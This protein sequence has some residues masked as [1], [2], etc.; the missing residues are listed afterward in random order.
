MSFTYTILHILGRDL[1]SGSQQPHTAAMPSLPQETSQSGPESIISYTH[2]LT[3]VNISRDRILTNI[4][5][6]SMIILALII[7]LVRFVQMG[8]AHIRHLFT[9][10]STSQQQN[11]WSRDY[12]S[13]WPHLKKYLLYAPLGRKRHNREIKLSEATNVGT[14]PSRFHAILLL[15]YV[16]SN[17]IYCIL[18]DYGHK[19]KAALIAEVRGR[20]GVLAVVNMIP[21]ILLAGRNNPL[22]PMLKV[23]FDTYNLLH[24]WM[25]RIVVIESIAHT[26]AWYVNTTAAQGPDGSSETLTHNR[27][28]QYGLIG[29]VAMAIILV[30]SF[31][32]VRHAF[33]EIF[34]HLHQLLAFL[35]ILGVYVHIDIADLPQKPYIRAIVAI[36]VTERCIR[37]ARLAYLNVSR[38][39]GVTKVEVEALDGE[40]CR[41]TFALPRRVHVRPGTHVYAYLPTVSWWMSHPFSVAWT[42]PFVPT[43]DPSSLGIKSSTRPP[44]SPGSLEKHGSLPTIDRTVPTSVSLVMLARTGMTRTLYDRASAAPSNTLHMTGFVEGPY[45]GRDKLNSYGTVL[46]FAGGVGITHQLMALRSLLDGYDSGT[47]AARK[48]VLVWSVRSVEQLTW[49]RSW[50][51]EVLAMPGRR[52]VLKIMLFVTKPRSPREVVS[53]SNTVLMFPGRCSPR[54]LVKDE[55]QGR[56]GAMAVTVCGPGAFADEVRQAVREEGLSGRGGACIDFVEEAFTW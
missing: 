36:W 19:E 8:N 2:G 27:F 22:I 53:P 39:N 29:T 16:L 21:L 56:V 25:G 20:T 40:A 50:M 13:F 14:L 9:L 11:Y 38:K 23:S 18:L 51:D 52:E 54:V 48:I 41:V 46:L 44:L 1:E 4:L 35:V 7:L 30:Q 37:L 3:G 47:V 42:T 45:A 24:R 49:V 10:S 31:S 6:F 33:Y 34:L 15:L 43:L 28:L 32:I 55:V 12:T 5:W 17:F 26:I